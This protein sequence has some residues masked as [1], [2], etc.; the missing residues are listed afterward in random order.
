Y[1]NT[2]MR[3]QPLSQ[4]LLED[5]LHP[6]Q[7]AQDFFGGADTAMVDGLAVEL[8]FVPN[9]ID[10]QMG[11][12]YLEAVSR[13]IPRA[14]WADKPRAAETQLMATMWP[15]LSTAGVQFYFSVF[16]EPYLNFGLVGVIAIYLL[17]G[18]FWR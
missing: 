10:Y 17:F 9:S 1:R 18:I 16:G 15:Q 14:V 4:L 11:R 5:A 3:A 7:A 2:D 8:Q 13:P 12:T 6:G